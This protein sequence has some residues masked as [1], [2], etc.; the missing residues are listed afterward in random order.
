MKT[1]TMKRGLRACLLLGAFGVLGWSPASAQRPPGAGRPQDRAQ[2]EQRVR[3]RFAENMQRRLRLTE[4]QSE[5]LEAAVRGLQADR[6]ALAQ[7]ERAL[8]Q[9]MQAILAD[10]QASE[11][12]AT[13]VLRRMVDLRAQEAR[14]FQ[15]EQERLLEVLTPIQAVRFHAMR[16]QLAQ[17]IQQLRGGPAGAARRPGGGL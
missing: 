13:Q 2:L 16:E 12:E 5:A 1:L 7:D 8:R 9:R 14:L 11:E 10:D 3:A 17:R 15:E 6:M 4:E